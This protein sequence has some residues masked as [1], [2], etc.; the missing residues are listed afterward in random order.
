[1]IRLTRNTVF[2]T[3]C[4]KDLYYLYCTI[5][6]TGGDIPESA[7]WRKKPPTPLI[8]WRH[9]SNWCSSPRVDLPRKHERLLKEKVTGRR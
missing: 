5:R 7:E 4:G 6:V 9:H 2:Y 1:M 8:P 3:P